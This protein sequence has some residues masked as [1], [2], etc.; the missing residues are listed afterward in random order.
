VTLYKIW[1]NSVKSIS[2]EI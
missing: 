1:P 2:I